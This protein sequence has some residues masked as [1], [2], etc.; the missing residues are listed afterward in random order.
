VASAR[1]A[2][3][4]FVDRG[5][6][7]AVVTLAGEGVLVVDGAGARHVPAPRVTAIDTTAAGDAFAG[8][9]GAGL[10]RGLDLDAALPRAM[11]AGALTVTRRG[12]SPSLPAA[13]DV[14]AFMAGQP[15]G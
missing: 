6:G 11:A 12:A 7:H 2:G 4:W 9:L 14:D 5:V 1:R 10:A 15:G 13:G 3:R 8:Y